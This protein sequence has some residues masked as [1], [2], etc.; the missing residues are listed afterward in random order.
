MAV[1]KIRV[2]VGSA[3]ILGLMSMK[4][5]TAPTNCYLM[6][7]VKGKCSAN[8]GFCPQARGSK[9][10]DEKLSRIIWPE[11]SFK[12]FITS[13]KYTS[14][15]K[16]F[17]RICIQTLKY[18]ENFEELTEIIIEIKKVSNIPISVAIPPMSKEKLEKLKS[19]GVQRVGIALDGA[20][21]EIFEKIKGSSVNGPY[22][23]YAHFD[24]LRMAM[25]VFPQGF[26]STHIIIGLGETQKEALSLI[27]DLHALSI[28]VSLFAFT[29]IEGTEL[30]NLTQPDIVHFRKLQL[31]RYLLVNDKKDME[32]FAFN[33]KEDIINFDINK[34]ELWNII[35]DNIAF[36]T[37]GCPGCNRPYYT[38]KPS[39]PI[40]NFPRNLSDDEKNEAYKLLERFVN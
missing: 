33:S 24:G 25:D 23:W 21:P 6:Q 34:K 35:T 8:C 2:S 38:S 26:V 4:M 1:K 11:F 29:P 39:G 19:F 5:E 15:L 13:L 30:E 9:G 7:H 10:S 28:L 40:Y 22:S 20:T 32:N 18:P 3:T 14:P 12:D 36:M 27:S 16:K 17:Q 31:G 37:T